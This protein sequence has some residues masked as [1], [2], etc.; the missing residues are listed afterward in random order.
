MLCTFH[1][2]ELCE[3]CRDFIGLPKEE[4]EKLNISSGEDVDLQQFNQDD[5]TRDKESSFSF[6]KPTN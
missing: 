6:C 2:S 1:C 5:Y 4:S 3:Y